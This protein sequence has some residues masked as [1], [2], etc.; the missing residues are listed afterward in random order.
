[1]HEIERVRLILAREPLPDRLRE[2]DENAAIRTTH[3]VRFA[4]G[5]NVAAAIRAFDGDDLRGIE[6][7]R[8]RAL[9]LRSVLAK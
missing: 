2:N 4:V 8:V 5:L 1:V 9:D 3:G 7:R 6:H